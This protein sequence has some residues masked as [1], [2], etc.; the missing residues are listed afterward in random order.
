[1]AL[2]GVEGIK[3]NCRDSWGSRLVQDLGRDVRGA[4]RRLVRYRRYSM[5][6]IG[7]LALGLGAA[8]VVFAMV[9][10]VLLRPLPFQEPDRL[11]R[12][13]EVTPEG[14]LFSASDAN[15][16]DFREQVGG[17]SDLAA[18]QWSLSRPALLRDGERIGLRALSVTPN[19]F[20]TLGVAAALGRTFGVE[21]PRVDVPSRSV[22]LSHGAWKTVFGAESQILGRE[23]DLDGQVWTVVGVLPEEFRFGPEKPEIYLPF[24][25][26]P[27]R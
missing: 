9:D 22:V 1:M 18:H 5:V 21:E 7:S 14:D 11:V 25:L 8:L 2:G 24:V 16:V 17:L 20:R 12:F 19:F 10:A 6:V 15:L 3:E 26:D 13:W 27:H 23:L 4:C